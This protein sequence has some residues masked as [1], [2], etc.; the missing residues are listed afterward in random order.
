MFDLPRTGSNARLYVTALGVYDIEINAARAIDVE[1]A[2]G[3][4]DYRKRIRYRTFDVTPLLRQGANVIGAWLGDGWYCGTLGRTDRQQYGERPLLLAQLEATLT[5]G[6]QV[7]VATDDL[8]TWRRSPILYSDLVL[9]ESFDARQTLGAW[10]E[11]DYD[12]TGWTPVDVVALHD[13]VA[14]EASANQPVRVIDQREPTRTPQRRSGPH[15]ARRLIYDSART[16]SAAS[17]LTIRAPRGTHRYDPLRRATRRAGRTDGANARATT[18]DQFTCAGGD[19]EIYEPR[20][21]L[22]AF[23][24]VEVGGRF[25]ESA[26]EAVNGVVLGAALPRPVISSAIIALLNRLQS[27]IHWTQRGNFLDVPM[28]CL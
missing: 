15:G 1:L 6:T 11:P 24:F 4:T 28:D 23:Q 9:G 20:F 19:R 22:H 21:A 13:G 8:W 16:S 18:T 2:P 17:R 14:L 27:N 25:D 10:S 12:A 3:W 5:D 7:R 26:I